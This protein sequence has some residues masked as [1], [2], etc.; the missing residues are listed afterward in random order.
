[1][2]HLRPKRGLHEQIVRELGLEITRGTLRVGDVLPNEDN[3]SSGLGVSRTVTREAIKV[4]AEKGMVIS[5]PKKGTQIQPR[6][7]WNLL[8]QDILDWE[9]EVGPRDVFFR[10]LH[11]VRLILEPAASELAAKR[12]KP[13]QVAA[14]LEAYRQ[15]EASV[16]DNPAY[17]TADMQFH[18]AIARGAHNDL[19]T[20]MLD[21]ISAALISSRKVTTQ[22]P[23]GS[24]AALP[25][26][27]MVY[28]AIL[29][30]QPQRAYDAMRYL[31]IRAHADIERIIGANGSNA[32]N[33][34][35]TTVLRTL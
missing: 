27:Y 5:R 16:D 19:L 25:L 22:I 11:E 34:P 6:E 9:Y 28:D 2:A 23:G 29:N 8:D 17:I 21:T 7:C 15:M 26:H 1:M 14:M 12:A 32:M 24:R 10:R 35:T 4:L 13:E 30:Q 20:R 3:L 31:V 33:E 18:A